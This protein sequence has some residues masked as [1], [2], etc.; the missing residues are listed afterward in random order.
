MLL[1]YEDR[2]LAVKEEPR[3]SPATESSSTYDQNAEVKQEKLPIFQPGIRPEETGSSMKREMKAKSQMGR[4]SIHCSQ[5]QKSFSRPCR[6]R[7][8]M[9]IHM[10]EKPNCCT[11]CWKSFSTPDGLKLHLRSHTGEKP[12]SCTYCAKSFS[13]LN[14]Q[15]LHLRIHTGEK[16]YSCTYCQKC[17]SQAGTLKRHLKIHTG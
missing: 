9:M 17:F 3:F 8:H 5:C 12:Y 10:G 7:D 16:P 15:K 6:L 11:L 4:K 13:S 2:V 14:N 1:R